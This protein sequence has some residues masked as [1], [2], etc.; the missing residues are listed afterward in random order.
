MP[1]HQP[2][3]LRDVERPSR[4]LCHQLRAEQ[5]AAFLPNTDRVGQ[6]AASEAAP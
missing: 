5:L 4:R 2:I 3:A 6:T 1:N